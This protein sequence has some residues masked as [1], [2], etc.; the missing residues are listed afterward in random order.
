MTFSHVLAG[1]VVSDLDAAETWYTTLFGRGPDARPM[2]GLLEWHLASGSGLQ[3]WRDADRS[4]VSQL[5]LGSDD[6]DAEASRLREAGIALDGP[7]PG[8]GARILRLRD[9]DGNLVVV[10]GT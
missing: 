7:E 5:V 9:A 3:V 8:G 4:G 2:P 6:L 1:A 10:T